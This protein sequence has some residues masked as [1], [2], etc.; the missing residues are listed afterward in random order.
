MDRRRVIRAVLSICAVSLF[1]ALSG[2]V[3]G[4]IVEWTIAP[5]ERSS[6][7]TQDLE[8]LRQLL[9]ALGYVKG[10][11]GSSS[12]PNAEFFSSSAS[13]RFN[14]ALLPEGNGAIRVKLI[15][16]GAKELSSIGRQQMALVAETL[17]KEFGRARI[18]LTQRPS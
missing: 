4:A 7:S 5:N 8:R 15:E 14:I 10:G 9:G 12:M 13:D 3:P 16:H 11:A 2:C 6:A 18:T 1:L 17:D